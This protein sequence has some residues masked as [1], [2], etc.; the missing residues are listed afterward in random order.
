MEFTNCELDWK[1]SKP[2]VRKNNDP[3]RIMTLLPVELSNQAIL[4]E[5]KYIYKN[6]K[7]EFSTH[8]NG[9]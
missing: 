8:L 6:E 2:G 5:D 7:I 3:H 1:C 4:N 9:K